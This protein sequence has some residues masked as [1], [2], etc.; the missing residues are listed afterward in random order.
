MRYRYIYFDLDGTIID[1][2]KGVINSLLV[3]LKKHDLN[4]Y[5]VQ[6]LK[7][8]IIGPPLYE[9]LSNLLNVDDDIIYEIIKDFREHYAKIGVF[10]NQLFNGIK[11][12]L[13]N[14]YELDAQ[15]NILTSKP[16]NFAQ[17]I[18]LQHNIIHYFQN[19]DGAGADDKKSTKAVKLAG[20]TNGRE[21]DSVMIGD[22][23]EDIV[24]GQQNCVDTIA[25]TY[26]FDNIDLLKQ[27]QPTYMVDT[28]LKLKNILMG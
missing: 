21:K 6:T 15:L 24:A 28:T 22:R 11:D 17:E 3:A 4:N 19:I 9:G 14:L 5:S 20:T 8:T 13:K 7:Q 12:L 1:S 2:S 27:Q 26:G 18:L 10:Q 23:V 25:V 16:Q